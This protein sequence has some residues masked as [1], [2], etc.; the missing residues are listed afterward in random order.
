MKPDT[1]VLF[2]VRWLVIP[3]AAFAMMSAPRMAQAQAVAAAP[4]A[5]SAPSAA[6]TT[7]PL[8]A[9]RQVGDATRELLARQ[10]SG[11]SASSLPRPIAGDVADRSYQR[12]L[13]SFEHPI[14]DRLT[15][16]VR[17]AVSSTGN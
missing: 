6:D 7:Q 11:V 4:S 12:Y 13:K 9:P 2:I 16:T 10:A 3:A 17:R 1:K 5:P 8:A 15:S 14:P